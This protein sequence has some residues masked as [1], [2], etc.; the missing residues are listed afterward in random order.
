[1]TYA[2]RLSVADFAD[3][4]DCASARMRASS[5]LHLNAATVRQRTLMT[6]L[7]NDVCGAAAEA[8]VSKWLAIPFS[9]SVNTFHQADV[10]DDIGVRHSERRNA[11]LILRENDFPGHWYVLVVGTPPNMLIAGYI[12]GSDARQPQWLANPHGYAQAW[13][14]PQSALLPVDPDGT[15]PPCLRQ[16]AAARL[17]AR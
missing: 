5:R 14:V 9:S 12:H 16:T 6:R 15:V 8:A 3:A 7:S 17:L 2:V 11:R 10:A 4:V 13:M 1:M